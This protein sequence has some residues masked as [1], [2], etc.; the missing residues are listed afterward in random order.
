MTVITEAD[1]GLKNNLLALGWECEKGWYP[2]IQELIDKLNLVAGDEIY[3]TQIKE[4]FG[5]PCFY[6]QGNY[7][8]SSYR[9]IEYYESLSEHICEKCGEFYTSRLRVKNY[10]YKTICDKCAEELEYGD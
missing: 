9:L 10:W 1:P 6:Y 8:D 7:S 4:K 5:R 3:V 2:L